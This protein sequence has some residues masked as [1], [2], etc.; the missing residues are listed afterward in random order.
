MELLDVVLAIPF[1][2]DSDN[3]RLPA[4][5]VVKEK[6]S[7]FYDFKHVLVVDSG[8][9][10]FNRSATRNLAVKRSQEVSAD[11][12]VLCDADSIPEE[13]PLRAAIHD[14]YADGLIHY[15]FNEVWEMAGKAIYLVKAGRNVNQL[16]TR[17]FH[18]YGHSQGG[19]WIC[20]P[21]VWWAAGGQ[22][23]RLSGWG[24]ED[25]AMVASSN[26]LIG[27]PKHHEGVLMCLYHKRPSAAEQWIPE[28]VELLHRY[29]K[30]RGNALETKG[31]I[32]ERFDDFGPFVRPPKGS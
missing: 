8:H 30:A 27:H 25:R 7:T 4:F 13:E 1:R 20:R 24:C 5:Q 28:D 12:I 31:I 6:L 2:D 15:P 23:P 17:A 14:S 32:N 11:V 3:T 16:R 29:E 10:P 26:T 19:V 18:K 22:D 21:D 9:V